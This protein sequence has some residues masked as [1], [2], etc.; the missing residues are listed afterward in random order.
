MGLVIA[1]STLHFHKAAFS[2][3][4]TFWWDKEKVRNFNWKTKKKLEGHALQGLSVQ[5]SIFLGHRRI[6]IITVFKI[7]F[8]SLCTLPVRVRVEQFKPSLIW[9]RQLIIKLHK[10]PFLCLDNILC[11]DIFMKT[12]QPTCRVLRDMQS[13]EH[14]QS[15]SEEQQAPGL[16]CL[17]AA[18]HTDI[19]SDECGGCSS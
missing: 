5:M 1:W 10:A 6:Y 2:L 12:I 4:R 3:C 11:L 9:K 16:K 19:C 14:R 13:E 8:F 18:P 15:E 17:S 7:P